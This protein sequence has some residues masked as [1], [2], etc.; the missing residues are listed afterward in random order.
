METIFLKCPLCGTQK[1]FLWM[2]RDNFDL[3]R[4][5][6]CD[7]VFIPE[8]QHKKLDVK[9]QYLKNESSTIDYYTSSAKCDSRY[10]KRNLKILEKYARPEKILDVGCSTGTFIK[11]AIKRG[12]KVI[13]IEPNPQAVLLARKNNPE[14][15]IYHCFFDEYFKL[16]EKVDVIHIADVIEH[17]FDPLSLI[18]RAHDILRDKG[19]LMITTCDINSF[20]G[21]K[22]QIKPEEH[23][24]YFN[25]KSLAFAMEKAG[26][27]IICV[28]RLT[29]PR[30]F[31]NIHRSTL[32]MGLAEK[33]FVRILKGLKLDKIASRISE[34]LFYD[35]VL[36]MGEK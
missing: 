33:I 24:V 36:V 17:V 2:K 26:F 1:T 10:F 15:K 4:C 30:D 35:E 19:V 34:W 21:K 32:K 23:L 18:C 9:N 5:E 29:R 11:E 3:M 28:K 12:W 25:K 6:N 13:G 7:F 27:K 31:T 14:A 20:L 8:S 16:N 22:Y